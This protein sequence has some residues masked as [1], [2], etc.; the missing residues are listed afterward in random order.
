MATDYYPTEAGGLAA[1]LPATGSIL[2]CTDP[3]NPVPTIGGAVTSGEPVMEGGAFDQVTAPSVHGA[4]PP[5]LP[6]AARPDVLVF[7]TPPLEREVEIAGTVRL[8]VTLETDAPDIDLT[9][10][11][12]DWCPPNADYPK[13]FAM[14]LT[15]GILRLRYRDDWRSPSLLEPGRRY[16]VAVE[17][18]PVAARFL[19]G[20]RIRLDISGSNFPKFDVNPQTGEPEGRARGHRTA[21]T[22]IFLGGEAP[23]RLSLPVLA[24]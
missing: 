19:P 24:G 16:E 2:L 22:R 13:G 9:A 4:P 12:I 20:H 1:D 5:Y 17:L 7:A 14:N 11:L 18:L 8:A 3:G 15:D 6:L 23:A 10:K 21:E